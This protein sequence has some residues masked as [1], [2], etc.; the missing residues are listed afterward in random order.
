MRLFLIGISLT[1]TCAWAQGLVNG[2]FEGEDGNGSLLNWAP[3]SDGTG[4]ATVGDGG[5]SGTGHYAKLVGG[6]GT[7]NEASI[8][9]FIDCTE[10]IGAN[11]CTISFD[12]NFTGGNAPIH[13]TNISA[14]IRQNFT[15][16]NTQGAWKK[17]FLFVEAK[18]C[19]G[20][21]NIHFEV[22]E[23][24]LCIDNVVPGCAVTP[25]PSTFV[26][27]FGAGVGALAILRKRL[28]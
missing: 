4:S 5:P 6:G 21:M 25:E 7:N 1:A 9:Q 22:K 3:Y 24:T 2:N 28:K 19:K 15:P 11:Y 14:G 27:M 20:L 16:E 18:D 10:E 17:G 26:G 12:Y 8:F 23:G 13:M